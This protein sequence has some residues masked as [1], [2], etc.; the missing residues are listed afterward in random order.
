MTTKSYPA[1]QTSDW[2]CFHYLL[3]KGSPV[4]VINHIDGGVQ[5]HRL[6]TGWSIQ[7]DHNKDTILACQLGQKWVVTND[8]LC[9][10]FSSVTGPAATAFLNGNLKFD[11]EIVE[12]VTP[13]QDVWLPNHRNPVRFTRI[14]NLNF[15]HRLLYD[16]VSRIYKFAHYDTVVVSG[17]RKGELEK[18]EDKFS[19]QSVASFRRVGYF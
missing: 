7:I 1:P 17:E 9:R 14:Q 8:G 6:E 15:E 10:A 12:Y 16:A 19:T 4:F 18:M 3:E 11:Q 13:N 2:V 5:M